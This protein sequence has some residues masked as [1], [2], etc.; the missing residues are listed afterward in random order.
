MCYEIYT[1]ITGEEED[2]KIINFDYIFILSSYSD[3]YTKFINICGLLYRKS[4]AALGGVM[5]AVKGE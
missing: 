2:S 5:A 4:E 3:M 1:Q